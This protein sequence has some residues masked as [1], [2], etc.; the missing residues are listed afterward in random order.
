MPDSA[1]STEPTSPSHEPVSFSRGCW[2][3]AGWEPD[4]Y[5]RRIGARKTPYFGNGDWV[6]AWRERLESAAFLE[7]LSKSGATTLVTRFYKGFGPEIEREDWPSLQ[8]FVGRAHAAGLQ[9]WGYLQGQS[10]FGE[11]LFNERPE[12]ASW[13][14]RDIS[15]APLLWAGAYNRYA[16]CLNNPAYRE[17]MENV[18][19]EGLRRV[20]LDG[21]HMDNNYYR[22]C[23]C[24]RC[25][26]L[27]REWLTERGELELRTGIPVADSV[28]PPPLPAEAG[29][30]PDPLAIL[31]IEF[32]VR[33]RLRFLQAIRAKVRQ[34]KPG[35][36]LSGNPA[37]LR[38]Y[39]SRLTHALDPS[40][41][42]EACDSLC[43][44]NGNQ[45]RL[46][47]GRLYTQAD[48]HLFSE[49]AGLKAWVSSW[50]PGQYDS[51]PPEGADEIWAGLSEEF[52]FSHV[53]LGNNWALRPSGEE[54]ELL[55]DP[56]AASWSTFVEA[57]QFFQNLE[58]KL[59]GPARRQWGEVAL[60]VDARALAVC[61]GSDARIVQAF[62]HNALAGNLPIKIILQDQPVPAETH[63]ILLVQQ[64]ALETR[65]MNRL[66]G[67]MS[68]RQGGEIWVIGEC[69]HYD[70]WCVPRSRHRMQSWSQLPNVRA[71]PIRSESWLDPSV[72]SS[73]YMKGQSPLLTEIGRKE[74]A[75]IFSSLEGRQ[76]VHVEGGLGLLSNVEKTEKRGWFVH[77]RSF[78]TA[79]GASGAF[80]RLKSEYFTPGSAV[81]FSPQCPDGQTIPVDAK[82]GEWTVAVPPFAHYA[83]IQILPA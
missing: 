62:L 21:I 64:R 34:S 78:E 81:A 10:L 56:L 58:Q 82:E 44:E 36:T 70:E 2:F 23:Y 13:I 35:A 71:F 57:T 45:P 68:R 38:T 43:I 9:V 22:H 8:A 20:G 24:G 61:P 54:S 39:A 31:W 17:M 49:A 48:K 32:G 73:Q 65:E 25:K 1:A 79:P 11:F 6:G 30:L 72:A 46:E 74:F 42:G 63:T 83:G 28:E 75:H 47:N 15:G 40:C 29:L 55:L 4:R 19:D 76:I 3:W 37:F 16:P 67:E 60:Y 27:F 7:S 66:A 52:S 33:T 53:L 69:G 50:R 59:S 18:V 80:I 12:A 26:E 14:A 77:L 41:E 51:S 5:Y